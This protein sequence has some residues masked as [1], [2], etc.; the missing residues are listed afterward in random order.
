MDKVCQYCQALKF[1]NEAA[2]MCCAAGKVVL[3]PLPAPPE[4]LLSLLAGNSDD[5]KLLLRKIRKF[6]SCFQ[7]I[8]FGATKICDLANHTKLDH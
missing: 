8:S 3:P 4:P 7:M 6:N 5:S 2:G 1:R